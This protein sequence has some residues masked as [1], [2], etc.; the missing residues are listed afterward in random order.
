MKNRLRDNGLTIAFGGIF[1]LALLGQAVSGLA[2]FN[3]EQLKDGLQP[4]SFLT[5]LFSSSFGADVAE[6][7]QSEYLQFLLYIM[8]TVWLA[9]RGSPESKEVENVG[10]ESDED[11]HV[12][13]YS[14]AESPAWARVRGFRL[15]L[16]SNSLGLVM[17][18]IFL[19]SWTAQAV[20]GRVSFNAN[21][22]ASLQDPV[23]FVSYVGSAEFWNRTTQNWQSEFLAVGSMVVLS[24][25][26]RQ[27]G[28]P[29]SKPVGTSHTAT[30][31]E[32]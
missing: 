10:T 8:A 18:A 23:S 19:G 1:F 17:G 26:L 9:Q 7:W 28:S 30:G 31:V 21:R 27:R 6:N 15:W 20:A 14:T 32:G 24:V 12:A 5:Y 13:E 22:M 4:V 16:Y 3:N 25:Y 11:Q 2:Q 29:E